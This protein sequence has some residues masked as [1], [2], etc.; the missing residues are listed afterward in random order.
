MTVLTCM[1]F[2]SDLQGPLA[3]LNMQSFLI[4]MP[5]LS[6]YRKMLQTLQVK[7][8]SCIC[9]SYS[10]NGVDLFTN[11]HINL[12]YFC[13]ISFI[14]KSYETKMISIPISLLIV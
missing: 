5:I 12:Y 2:L 11:K 9:P 8:T 6:P 14:I 13:L 7:D 1:T 4:E 10:C 3:T